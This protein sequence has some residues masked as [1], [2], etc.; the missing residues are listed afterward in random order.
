M[1]DRF[2]TGHQ[3]YSLMSPD[4]V[5]ILLIEVSC[6]GECPK[7]FDEL[8]V[9]EYDHYGNGSVMVWTGISVNGKTGLYVIET[10]TA[11][12]Y[13]NE[14]LNQFVRPYAGAITPEFILIDDNARAHVTRLSG[15]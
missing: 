7:R 12:R 10:F 8:N 6:C 2:V 11:L 9:A 14:F 15:M 1:Q 4:S 5:S 13:C 3:C